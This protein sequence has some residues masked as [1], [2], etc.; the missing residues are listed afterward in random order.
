M[1]GPKHHV[2]GDVQKSGI[3]EIE[4]ETS[5]RREQRGQKVKGVGGKN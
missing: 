4:G 2:K 3:R 5:G 1:D